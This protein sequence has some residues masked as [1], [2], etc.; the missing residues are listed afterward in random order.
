[1]QPNEITLAVD[2]DNSGSGTTNHVYTRFE[3]YL[4][5]AVYI[6]GSHALSAR[7]TLSLYRTLPKPSGNFKG[8]A[9]CALKFS[10]DILVDGVDGVSQLTSPIIV[11]V[12]MSVPVG[13][14]AAQCL[15]A[16]QRAVTLL[17]NDTIMVALMEQQMI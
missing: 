11:E 1:M 13:A 15:I 7:D 17:D 2:E 14:T 4:N 16:R 8:V 6:S 10:Q 3:E 5:R 9:K 12:S